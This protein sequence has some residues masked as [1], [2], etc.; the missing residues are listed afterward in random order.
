MKR[1][2]RSKH[3]RKK[4]S[5]RGDVQNWFLN[6][7]IFCLA[8]IIGGFI[9]STGKRMNDNL[10][11]VM[12][13][14]A[15]TMSAPENP[16]SNIIIEVLNGTE[17]P[18]LALEFTNYLRQQGFDVIASGNASRSDVPQTILIQ[19]ADVPEKLS[20]VNATLSLD[21]GRLYDEKDPSLQVDMTLIIGKDYNTLPVYSK[22]QSIKEN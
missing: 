17:K 9:Y 2:V 13:S 10:Q 20:S 18:G 15:E 12:L 8:V 19:R 1:K 11:K 3:N 7:A 6:V 22:I 21:S 16:F 14:T 4:Q 5:K